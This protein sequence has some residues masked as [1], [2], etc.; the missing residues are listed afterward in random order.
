MLQDVGKSIENVK[1][2]PRCIPHGQVLTGL[3]PK[4]DSGEDDVSMDFSDATLVPTRG[5]HGHRYSI[6]QAVL[7]LGD[8]GAEQCVVVE[9]DFFAG[10]VEAD[11]WQDKLAST[12]LE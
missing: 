7:S 8:F 1:R 12:D 9:D 4:I 6:G 10:L 11:R 5:N 3:E 2:T